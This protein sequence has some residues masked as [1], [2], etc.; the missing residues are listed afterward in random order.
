M[1]NPYKEWPIL[2]DYVPNL[3]GVTISGNELARGHLLK[4]CKVYCMILTYPLFVKIVD[5]ILVRPSWG[6]LIV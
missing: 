4:Q 1:S 5:R 6:T 3:K 2:C